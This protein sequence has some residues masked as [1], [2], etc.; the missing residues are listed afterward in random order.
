MD[1]V[2]CIVEQWSQGRRELYSSDIPVE[3]VFGRLAR[4]M[5]SRGSL[6]AEN[7]HAHYDRS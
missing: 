2:A 5:R 6:I 4:K 1:P 3:A 7:Y